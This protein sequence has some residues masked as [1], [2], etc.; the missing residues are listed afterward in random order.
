[1]QN[2][3][4]LLKDSI[5]AAIGLAAPVLERNLDFDFGYFLNNTLVQEVQI[6]KPGYNILRR[7]AAVVLGQWLP[8]KEGLNR[9]LVYQIFQHLLDKGDR[10]NDQVVRVTAGRQL[11]NVVDPFEFAA[12]PFMPYVSNIL[13]S[14][15]ALV[16]EVEL[17]ETKMALLNTISVIVARM[18]QHVCPSKQRTWSGALTVPDFSLC[19]SNHIPS[20]SSLG[21]SWRRVPDETVYSRH[22]ISASNLNAG[23][24]PEIPSIDHSFDSIFHRAKLR[25]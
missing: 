5:Y 15:M 18:E 7:R 1:M 21:P 4:V 2:T 20:S 17:P 23:G 25:K 12:E 22:I 19:G 10:L 8:V 9:T 3:E 11:R 6:S 16:E 14:L 24:I 13:G